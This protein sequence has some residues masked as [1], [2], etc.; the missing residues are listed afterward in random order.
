MGGCQGTRGH[1][2]GS[3]GGQV[4]VS[5]IVVINLCVRSNVQSIVCHNIPLKSYACRQSFN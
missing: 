4:G 2:T 5:K 3:C 1:G